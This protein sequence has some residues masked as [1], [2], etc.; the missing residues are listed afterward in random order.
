MATADQFQSNI[1]EIPVVIAING[2]VSGIALLHGLT[3]VGIGMPAAFTGTAITLQAGDA[4]GTYR[5]V[6]V[7]GGTAVS[8]TV[9]ADKYIALD[10]ATLRGIERLKLVSGNTETAARTITI[11][12]RPIQ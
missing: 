7:I 5:A 2:T 6:N 11:F 10:P 9:A 1:V 8:L 12:A 4:D 3:V